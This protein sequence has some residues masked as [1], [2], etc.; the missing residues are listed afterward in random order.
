MSSR[1]VM[2]P[3]ADNAI[4]KVTTFMPAAAPCLFIDILVQF[5]N[6]PTPALVAA[7]ILTI[8][9]IPDDAIFNVTVLADAFML[10]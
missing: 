3:I 8:M 6:G 7:A 1:N 2:A 4:V 10:L 9:Y 5:E